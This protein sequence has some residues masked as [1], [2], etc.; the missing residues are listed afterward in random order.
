MRIIFRSKHSDCINSNEFESIAISPTYFPECTN[1]TKQ[2]SISTS[3][4]DLP[5]FPPSASSSMKEQKGNKSD[6]C[7]M[8]TRSTVSEHAINNSCRYRRSYYDIANASQW[9]DQTHFDRCWLGE[10]EQASA[11]R[12]R[13]SLRK[14]INCSMT[15]FK[16]TGLFSLDER[17]RAF[18]NSNWTNSGRT[19]RAS[20]RNGFLFALFISFSL[21]LSVCF[22][23][24]H[25]KRYRLLCLAIKHPC[26]WITC[27]NKPRG[28]RWANE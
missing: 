26:N 1:A 12:K 16:L 15:E 6:F 19:T 23:V 24:I 7:F 18:F 27:C 11:E 14:P 20:E 22:C 3:F 13:N 8:W 9:L 5:I 28:V 10:R 17:R 21:P 25:L 2:P 4:V